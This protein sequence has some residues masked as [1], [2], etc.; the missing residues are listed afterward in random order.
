MVPSTSQYV[1]GIRGRALTDEEIVDL[2]DMVIG[3][4]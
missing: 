4:A 2:V 1:W 3:R